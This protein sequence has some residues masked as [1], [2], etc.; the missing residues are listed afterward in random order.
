MNIWFLVLDLKKIF[1]FFF[2]TLA[3]AGSFKDYLKLIDFVKE[4]HLEYYA[5]HDA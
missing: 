4:F 2:I 3:D 5:N 1:F